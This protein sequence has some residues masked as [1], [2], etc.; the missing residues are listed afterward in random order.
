MRIHIKLIYYEEIPSAKFPTNN[1]WEGFLGP[2][3]SD[4]STFI[5]RPLTLVPFIFRTASS[6]ADSLS[7]CTNL[8]YETEYRFDLYGNFHYLFMIIWHITI[9]E[10]NLRIVFDTFTLCHRSVCL[11]KGSQIIWGD[12]APFSEIANIKFHF[13]SVIEGLA[14]YPILTINKIWRVFC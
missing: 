12:C 1:F 10:S 7:M 13:K 8:C 14:M 3:L 5:D 11:E 2:L 9:A 6:A 4:F